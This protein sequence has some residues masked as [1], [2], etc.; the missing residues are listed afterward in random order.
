MVQLCLVVKRL[1][2]AE[3]RFFIKMSVSV[4][5]FVTM[6]AGIAETRSH[7]NEVLVRRFFELREQLL[8]QRGTPR[9][10]I[11][12]KWSALA[13]DFRAFVLTTHLPDLS[14]AAPV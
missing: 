4:L 6:G 2:P 5:L 7:S 9:T 11:R 1:R 10:A 3:F 12:F 8:D 13:D 14:K